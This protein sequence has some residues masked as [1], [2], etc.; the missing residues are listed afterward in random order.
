[1]TGA[2]MAAAARRQDTVIPRRS[3]SDLF[4][5]SSETA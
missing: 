1:M 3:G 4:A 2:Q 5:E